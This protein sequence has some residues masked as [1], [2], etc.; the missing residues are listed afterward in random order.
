MMHTAEAMR[1]SHV[2]RINNIASKFIA[3][4]TGDIY[5]IQLG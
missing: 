3:S 4:I 2:R 5:S 1:L